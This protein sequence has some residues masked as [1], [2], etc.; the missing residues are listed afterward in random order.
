MRKSLRVT[1]IALSMA[2]ALFLGQKAFSY[3]YNP[4]TG[5][6]GQGI[7]GFTPF[8][9]APTLSPFSLGADLFVNYGILG[10]LDVF[11]DL[12]EVAIL[13]NFSYLFSSAMVRYDIGGNNIVALQAS[14]ISIAPQYHFFW[15]NDVIAL[16]A[17]A[18]VSF[19]YASFGTP[20]IGA[21][22]APVWK[23]IKDAVYLY[24]E[25]DPS[26]TIQGSFNLN[27]VPGLW[28]GFGSAGQVSLAV[29]LPNL[30]GGV[31]ISPSVNLW[32]YIAFDLNSKK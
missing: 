5:M 17:N 30:T 8:V 11:V 15:E 18:Y 28:F 25:V 23:M 13:P 19:P 7:L 1:M 14:Q 31:G 10:N 24:V 3:A 27:V 9:Y 16:E 6:T 4:W 26:Y 12:A 2:G 21:Y 32:Y 22:L 20:T 29:T